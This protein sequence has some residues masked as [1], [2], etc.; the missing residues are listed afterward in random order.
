MHWVWAAAAALLWPQLTLLGGVRARREP[1]RPRK[2]GQHPAAPNATTSSSE[3][4]LGFPKLPEASGPEFTDAHMTWLNFVRRPDDGASKKRCRGQDK[5]SRGPPGPPGP[6]GAEVTQE[7]VLRE[8]QGMLKEATERRSSAPLGPPLPEGTGRWLVS[9]AFHCRLK[10]PV[11]VDKRTLVEL[12]GFQAPAAQ[13]AFLRG[14]GLSL[15]SGRFTAPVTAIFQF[16][17]SLHVGER[18][19]ARV[20]VGRGGWP[21]GCAPGLGP[22]AEASPARTLTPLGAGRVLTPTLPNLQCA[23]KPPSPCP[24]CSVLPEG[25]ADLACLRRPQGAAGQ[26][27]AA[28]PGHSACAGLHRVPVPSPHVP[29]GH[30]RPGERRQGL[31][32]ARA[33]A[34]AAAGGTVHLRLCGQWLRCSPHRPEQLQLLR[35]APGHVRGRRAA[36]QL[37]QPSPRC[38]PVNLGSQQ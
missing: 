1:K 37:P 18:G 2:P 35:P 10:G 20:H 28:G 26:G 19:R 21:S 14:S 7:A 8:F 3:G 32:G 4:L 6:P 31:H 27:P 16:F 12:Q 23:P 36:G 25:A 24:P 15:A 38:P 34:A 22:I 17:A 29:G 13:G 33:G 5:K 30:L 11:L 9:E